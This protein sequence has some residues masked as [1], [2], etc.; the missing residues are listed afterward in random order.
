MMAFRLSDSIR[1]DVKNIR[2]A[3]DQVELAV[4]DFYASKLNPN[5]YVGDGHIVDKT[6][7]VSPQFDIIICENRKNPVFF[8]LADK[9]DLVFFEPV[10][11]FGE[12]KKSV[13]NSHLIPSFVENIRR[14]NSEMI[15]EAIPPNYIETSGAGLLVDENVTSLPIRN[16]IFKFMFFIDSSKLRINDL[17]KVFT[18]PNV[19]KFALPNFIVFLDQG[20]FVNIN[21]KSKRI[22]NIQI[23]L[24]PEHENEEN[25]W[26]LLPFPTS[27]ET[28]IY[29]YMLILDHLNSVA[30]SSTDVLDY[31]SSMFTFNPN[32]LI[33]L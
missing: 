6:L 12:I 14:L 2:A 8:Q 30:T 19:D 5:Y 11:L 31:T 33:T 9:S 23:N 26:V 20:L 10:L 13:Y 24:Y 22:G 21:S 7:K 17:R 28:L 18:G 27:H 15:R 32:N 29:Q 1:V 25:E 4:K 16:P 3:G